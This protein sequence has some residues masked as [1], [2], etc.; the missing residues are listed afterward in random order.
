MLR[1]DRAETRRELRSF[2]LYPYRKYRGDANWVPPLRISQFELLDPKKNPFW[3]HARGTFYLA[4]REGQVVGRIACIDD[5]LHN[6]THGDDLVFFGF[7]EAEDEEV[8]RALLEAVE[9]EA[10]ALGRTA[11]RGPAN[12]T[13]NDGAGF[14]IDSFDQKAYVM[15]PQN[16]PHYPAWAEAAGYEKVKDLYTFHLNNQGSMPER[17][18]RIV[19]RTRQRYQP[20][21]RTADMKRFE[22]EVQLL[23]RIHTAAWEKNWGQVP[24]T[25]AEI[26]HLASE[27]KMIVN[28]EMALFLEYQGEPVAVCIAIPDLNQVLARFDG[29]LLPTGIFHLLN[30]KRT[31]DRARLVMLGVLPEHRNRGFDLVLIDEVM[32]R[33]HSQGIREG[34]LGWTLEDN[35]AI[36]RA[37]EASGGVRNKTF[38]MVQK[39]LRTEP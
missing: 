14:Q 20:V 3:Q 22:E 9:D 5:D 36:N 19:D 30:M 13:M 33:G 8:A 25:D 1:I 39:E 2:V 18:Q 16:P 29:R 34:E 38:R 15:M 7:F 10:R 32:R 26:R 6:A 27:L 21:V 37:I 17:L 28:P 31:I 12:P 24:Y 4:R 35:H 23:Q 11:V